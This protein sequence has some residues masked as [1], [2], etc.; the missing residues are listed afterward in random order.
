MPANVTDPNDHRVK[1]WNGMCFRQFK[2][3]TAQ[4]LPMRWWALTENSHDAIMGLISLLSE[5]HLALAMWEA[6]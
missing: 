4:K 5:D 3:P 1:R 6:L 2:R